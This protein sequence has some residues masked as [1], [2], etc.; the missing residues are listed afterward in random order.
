MVS[1]SLSLS[2]LICTNICIKHP[3]L[4]TAREGDFH[5]VTEGTSEAIQHLG[6]SRATMPGIKALF[7]N[8]DEFPSHSRSGVLNFGSIDI[9][10]QIILCL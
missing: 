9:W 6:Q 10:G 2:F 3:L 5:E 8:M 7:W 1:T 4:P